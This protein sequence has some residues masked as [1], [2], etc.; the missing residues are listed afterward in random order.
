LDLYS[1]I[2][3]ILSILILN[4]HI[5]TAVSVQIGVFQI[6]ILCNPGVGYQNLEEHVASIFRGEV[7]RVNR[8]PCFTEKVFRIVG[9]LN[10]EKETLPCGQWERSYDAEGGLTSWSF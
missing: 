9:S 7:T 6:M 5:F 10:G 2:F 3:I 8:R 4:L 1:S